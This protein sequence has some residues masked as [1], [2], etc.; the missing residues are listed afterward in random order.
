MQPVSCRAS[1]QTSRRWC[2]PT[3]SSQSPWRAPTP[4]WARRSTS[5]PRSSQVCLP[6]VLAAWCTHKTLL[7]SRRRLC[8]LLL[9]ET[10]PAA[11]PLVCPAAASPLS[12][13]VCL[14]LQ[15]QFLDQT[16]VL[17]AAESLSRQVSHAAP[18]LP[19]ALL[20]RCC[21]LSPCVSGLSGYGVSFAGMKA[22][23][24]S[25]PVRLAAWGG[26]PQ[27][28]AIR[29]SSPRVPTRL[30]CKSGATAR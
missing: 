21:A 27:P 6:S 19:T 24:R 3:T 4:S 26:N 8:L 29:T 13:Q 2:W 14:P 20:P 15:L 1:R 30:C 17:T 25:A 12:S 5:P 23:M 7:H 18:L 9:L 10:L 22:L 28:A 16:L 11:A